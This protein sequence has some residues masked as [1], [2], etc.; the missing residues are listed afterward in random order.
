MQ[1]KVSMTKENGKPSTCSNRQCPAQAKTTNTIRKLCPVLK[2]TTQQ[3]SQ[4]LFEN[5]TV[6]EKK[7]WPRQHRV[8]C[9]D[10]PR[11]YQKCMILSAFIPGILHNLTLVLQITV[12]I[13]FRRDAM[14][15]ERAADC[16]TSGITRVSTFAAPWSCGRGLI[17]WRT[18][19]VKFISS[20]TSITT[21]LRTLLLQI[22]VMLV[23][24][25]LPVSCGLQY[26]QG[27]GF[28]GLS[29]QGLL[30]TIL[31]SSHVRF[32]ST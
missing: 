1:E 14:F 18:S 10:W 26:C 8:N 32:Y 11:Y 23:R 22:P 16:S 13:V 30:I 24:T 27:I 28:Q 12:R 21:S 4:Y 2:R 29:A 19:S 3:P 31:Q 25:Q 20:S 9:K 6:K 15:F 5:S 7:N 17:K